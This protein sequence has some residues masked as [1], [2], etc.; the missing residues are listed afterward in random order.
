MTTVVMQAEQKL[1]WDVDERAAWRPP[2]PL[3]PSDWAERH[4]FLSRA[5]SDR[6]GPWRNA[7]APYLPALM[8]LPTRPG[9]AQLNIRKAAQVGVSEAMRNLIGYWAERE[10]DPVGLTLPNER[11]GREIVGDRVLPLFRRTDVLRDLTTGRSHDL[12]TGKIRLGNGFTL[13]LMWAGSAA[14]MASDPMRRVVNDEVDKFEEWTGKEADPISLTWKRLR[15]YGDRACQINVSTP[16]TRFGVIQQL[17]EASDVVLHYAV[18]CPHCGAM[19]EMKLAGLRLDYQGA[20]AALVAWHRLAK[21]EGPEVDQ[22]ALSASIL[23]ESKVLLP[24]NRWRIDPR[25]GAVWYECEVC[26][27]RIKPAER[28]EMVRRGRWRSDDGEIEDADAVERW[29]TG[30]RIGVRLSALICLWTSW[31]SIAAEYIR[32]KGHLSA[33]YD[34]YTQTLGEPFEQQIDKVSV[35]RF[36]RLAA[37]ADL[38]EGIVPSWASGL[39]LTVDTQKDHFWCVVRAWGAGMRSARVWH[40]RVETFEHLEELAS[41]RAWPVAR[42]ASSV[43]GGTRAPMIP[44]RTFIDSGG[45]REEG[46]KASRTAE[47]YKWVLAH[48]AWAVAIKGSR[49]RAGMHLWYGKGWMDDASRKKRQG[50]YLRLMFVDS[51]HFEDELAEYIHEGETEGGTQRWFLNRRDDEEYAKHLAAVHKITFRRGPKMVHEWVPKSGGQRHDL[52][53]CEVYQ[54]AAAYQTKVHLLATEPEAPPPG[55]PAPPAP[56]APPEGTPQKR[57]DGWNVQGFDRI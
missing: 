10:P 16:T 29:P 20:S 47:V 22:K 32:A 35:G 41:R 40:G 9:V 54:I 28:D 4:R 11:K 2:E 53:D 38:E 5:E 13:H 48:R 39:I 46:E 44:Y 6:D 26:K 8:N 3:L 14:S 33:F 1:P 52:R 43:G 25:K 56:P 45:T 49:P 19:Q 23:R 17:L 42:A 7:A 24:E 57:R 55:T 50:A 21:T 27:G 18:P 30:T 36:S 37:Q 51:Q 15:S 31:S 34:F 12:K